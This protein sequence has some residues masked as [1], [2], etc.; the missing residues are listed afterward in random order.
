M[1]KVKLSDWL[2]KETEHELTEAECKLSWLGRNP[3]Y[4]KCGICNTSFKAGDIVLS[5]YTNYSGSSIS[6]NPIV[7]AKHG[8]PAECKS[9]LEEMADT[10]RKASDFIR[11]L[12]GISH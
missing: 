11:R 7:C 5:L 3:S 2:L 10:C 4:L 1:D 8:T 12:I 6:G 9:K